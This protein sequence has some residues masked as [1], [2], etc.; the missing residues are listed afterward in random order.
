MK[1]FFLMLVLALSLVAG[2]DA[3][4]FVLITAVSNYDDEETNLGQTTK[5]ARRFKEVIQNQTRDITTLTSSNATRHNI[6]EKLTAIA[7]RAQ[8]DDRIIFFYS[9]HGMPGAIYT[10]D[11]PVYYS[12]INDILDRSEAGQKIIYIDACHAGS[13]ASVVT[14]TQEGTPSAKPGTAYFV[15]SRPEETSKELGALGAGYFTQA[16]I[17]GLRGTADR[18]HDRKV[19]VEELFTYMYRDIVQRSNESQHPQL[20]APREMFSTVLMDWNGQ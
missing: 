14:N 10:Y 13:A 12:E 8:S 6:A 3:R 9:G 20:I 2:V 18:N 1:R 16:L 7:N 4:T 15:S 11:G 17:K 19:T 5:D